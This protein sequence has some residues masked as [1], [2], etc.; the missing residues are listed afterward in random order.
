ML[1]KTDFLLPHLKL[2][3]WHKKTNDR[4]IICPRCKVRTKLYKLQDGRRKCTKCGKKTIVCT[5][6]YNRS[7]NRGRH[8]YYFRLHIFT[9]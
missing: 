1:F 5:K 3:K 4:H 8:V 2:Q 6:L 9:S 7:E